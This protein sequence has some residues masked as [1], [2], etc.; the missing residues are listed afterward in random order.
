MTQPN[1]TVTLPPALYD[2]I[3]KVIDGS[4]F[5]TVEDLVIFV[6]E[7]I[8]GDRQ[9]EAEPEMTTYELRRIKQKLRALGYL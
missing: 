2:R 1:R 9:I 3:A 5:Q 7:D 6:L 8:V 4:K